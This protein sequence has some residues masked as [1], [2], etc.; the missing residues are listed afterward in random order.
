[1]PGL[2]GFTVLETMRD[3]PNLQDLP[4]IVYTAGDLQEDQRER[5]AEFSQALLKKGSVTVEELLTCLEKSLQK[6]HQS[7]ARM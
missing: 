5:L 1:M 6:Y 7:Q 2:G 4:V 3:D